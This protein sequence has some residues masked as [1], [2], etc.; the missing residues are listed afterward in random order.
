[1]A[2]VVGWHHKEALR[3][4][5]IHG[6]SG[7]YGITYVKYAQ[8]GRDVYERA[9]TSGRMAWQLDHNNRPITEKISAFVEILI[10]L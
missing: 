5:A 6:F 4:A 2:I 8:R 1:M 10:R 7:V 9:D 3:E